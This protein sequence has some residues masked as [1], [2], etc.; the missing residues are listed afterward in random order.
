VATENQARWES[1]LLQVFRKIAIYTDLL[2]RIIVIRSIILLVLES[3]IGEWHE[4]SEFKW[5]I[6]GIYWITWILPR[7]NFCCAKHKGKTLFVTVCIFFWRSSYSLLNH[8]EENSEYL[9][10]KFLFDKARK[11]SSQLCTQSEFQCRAGNLAFLRPNCENL[12]VFRSGLAANILFGL[13]AV[14]EY[15]WKFG[16]ISPNVYVVPHSG[17]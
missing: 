16:R 14:F 4:V 12:A 15:F 5:F 7:T 1:C 3:N 17:I 13:L 9:Y 10:K 8:A 11:I 6:Y 2:H